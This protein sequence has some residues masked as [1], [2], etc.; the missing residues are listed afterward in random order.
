MSLVDSRLLVLF[1]AATTSDV[2]AAV[3]SDTAV[4]DCQA[5]VD[6]LCLDN[7][8]GRMLISHVFS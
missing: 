6:S 5:A 7:D 4:T 3:N 8:D 1:A 2:S